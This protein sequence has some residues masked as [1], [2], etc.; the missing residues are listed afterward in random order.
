VIKGINFIT[1]LYHVQAMSLPLG[2]QLIEKTET[3]IDKKTGKHQRPSALTKNELYQDLIRQAVRN[4]IPFTYVLN[5]VWSA[6]AVN[7]KPIKHEIQRDFIMPLK[8]NCKPALS[9]Q[10]KQDGQYGRVDTLLLEPGTV[11][12]IC[13]EGVD[14]PLHLVKQ[15]FINEDDSTVTLYWV[16]SNHK[17]TYD[18]ITTLYGK[19][20]NVEPYHT[21]LKQNA[22]LEKS[23]AR[24]ETTQITHFFAAVCAYLKLEMLKSTTH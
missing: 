24:T 6:S 12:T 4:R 5:D 17:L 20:W 8:T 3:F 19:R 1:A 7:T 13:L 11:L 2:Y 18:Q 22:S 21:S 9:G 16:S 15:V 23:P 14:F 10:D